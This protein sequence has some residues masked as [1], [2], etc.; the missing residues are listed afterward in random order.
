M[1]DSRTCGLCDGP[2]AMEGGREI[3]RVTLCGDCQ[4]GE[5]GG[6]LVHRGLRL[7]VLS[8]AYHASGGHSGG[9]TRVVSGA[10]PYDLE[11]TAE[12][13]AEDGFTR[14]TKWFSKELQVGDK[15]FDDALYIGTDARESLAR[16]LRH[17]GLREAILHAVDSTGSP[18]R[19]TGSQVASMATPSSRETV[20][21]AQ[22]ALALCLH[23]LLAIAKDRGLQKRPDLAH[24]PD[25]KSTLDYVEGSGLEDNRFW[26][27][28]IF[29]EHATVDSLE[30][31]ARIHQAM[32]ARG[33][34]LL[35]TLRIEDCHLISADLSPLSTLTDLQTLELIGL[36]RATTLPNLSQLDRLTEL[37]L[38][39]CPVAD[40]A[41]IGSPAALEKLDLRGSQVTDLGP[42]RL[43]PALKTLWIAGLDLSQ[44]QIADVRN[45]H[46]TLEL[47]PY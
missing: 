29:L 12:F 44:E 41:S 5:F 23:H 2:L 24:Y 28:A 8:K 38:R 34:R 37:T 35:Q 13:S 20:A 45:S 4:A 33:D 7:G 15:R 46:P 18:L 30:A 25:L 16:L 47:D 17:E 11:V 6:R 43:L 42:L 32:S 1:G 36:S 40:L 31:V 39:D 10:I 3:A 22:L 26:P 14:F 21:R 27:K 9:R 19:L